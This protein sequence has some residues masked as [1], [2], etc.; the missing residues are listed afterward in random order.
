MAREEAS[1]EGFEGFEGSRLSRPDSA[2]GSQI[3]A[4]LFTQVKKKNWAFAGS[5]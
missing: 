5:G 3:L 4:L 1:F 2:A